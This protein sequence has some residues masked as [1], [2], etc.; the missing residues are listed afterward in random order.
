M[1]EGETMPL[2]E[3]NDWV[4]INNVTFQIH[5]INDVIQMQKSVLES[6]KH[7]VPCDKA[8]FYLTER[9]GKH[10][11]RC[12]VGI[13][14]SDDELQEYIDE[15]EEIDYLKYIALSAKSGVYRH[16]DFF[17]DAAREE[18]EY[19][20]ILFTPKGIHYGVLLTVVFNDIYLGA[21]SLYRS[22]SDM[23]FSDRELFIL[24]LLKEHLGLRLYQEFLK[25]SSGSG[26]N[27][28]GLSVSQFTEHYRLTPR[29]AEIVNL[30]YKGLTND[31]ICSKLFICMNTL[32]R[33]NLNI[34]KKL[35]IKSRLQLFRLFD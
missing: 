18:T 11:F 29:E 34:Y 13:N 8:S 17:T 27:K 9:Q 26:M 32:K 7:M 2:L 15:Y 35:G 16:T 3:T 12:P 14:I 6:L 31:E 22:K 23:D 20:K 28:L 10:V 19:Y 1:K 5:A 24:G 4:F 33:H 25:E 30:L 21:V